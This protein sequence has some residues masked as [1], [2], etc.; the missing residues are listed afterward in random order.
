MVAD[1]KPNRKVDSWDV[2]HIKLPIGTADSGDTPR[3]IGLL[4]AYALDYDAIMLLDGDNWFE[5]SHAEEMLATQRKSGAPIVTC[6]RL[7]RRLDETIMAVCTESDGEIFNDFNC[8][9][10]TR[11]ALPAIRALA[12]HDRRKAYFTDRYLW[13]RLRES[14]LPIARSTKPTVNYETTIL[15]HYLGNGEEPP[16]EAKNVVLFTDNGETKTLTVKQWKELRQN[17]A[18]NLY[19]IG[20]EKPS[21]QD[22]S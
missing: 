9:L 14:G 16:P 12:F 21:S 15:A 5:P 6:P 7:L 1:G 13:H 2:Q 8:Y 10:F 17:K 18:F 11:D 3:L 4:I 19:P 20:H 22:A